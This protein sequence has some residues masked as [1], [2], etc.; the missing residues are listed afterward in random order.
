MLFEPSAVQKKI[1]TRLQKHSLISLYLSLSSFAIIRACMNH[2]SF[3]CIVNMALCKSSLRVSYHFYNNASQIVSDE[4][5]W[6][7]FILC[8]TYQL[9]KNQA[10]EE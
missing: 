7:T 6:T 9:L 5:K 10:L 8:R 4:H 3:V 2:Q 1:L